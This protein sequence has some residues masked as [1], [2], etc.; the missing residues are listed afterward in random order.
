MKSIAARPW[1]R[2]SSKRANHPLRSRP[3]RSLTTVLLAVVGSVIVGTTASA[4]SVRVGIRSET[5]AV[6]APRARVSVGLRHTSDETPSRASVTLRGDLLLDWGGHG[7]IW[8]SSAKRSE[9]RFMLRPESIG[10]ARQQR[11]SPAGF[12]FTGSKVTEALGRGVDVTYRSTATGLEQEFTIARRPIGASGNVSL[13]L[14]TAGTLRAVQDRSGTRIVGDTGTIFHYGGLHVTDRSGRVLPAHLSVVGRTIR[15]VID[16]TNAAYPVTVDPYVIPPTSPAATFSGG[17]L[18]GFSVALSADGQ[19]ALVGT[20]LAY[21]GAAYLAT[22]SSGSW[23][24]TPARYIFPLH[25]D[26]RFGTS[27]ALSSNGTTALVGDPSSN[28][29]DLY[30]ESGGSWTTTPVTF[31]GASGSGFGTSVALSGDGETVLVGAPTSS[32][33]DLYDTAPPSV[34]SISPSSGPPSGGTTVTITG[35]NLEQASAVDFGSGHPATILTDTATSLTVT[36]PPESAGTVDITV[37]TPNGTSATSSA[38]EFSYAAP[39]KIQRIAPS[40]GPASGGTTVEIFGTDLAHANAVHFGK[41]AAKI[42]RG[43]AS[44]LTVISPPGTGTVTVTVTTSG[45]TSSAGHFT[46]KAS[47]GSATRRHRRSIV[48]KCTGICIFIQGGASGPPSS[49]INVTGNRVSLGGRH[50]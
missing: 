42:T 11:F 47:R 29:A 33:A 46:Y 30:T 9:Q 2:S 39:P 25:F 50:S 5:S 1:R 12:V 27:V 44:A 15:L 3:A 13:L 19:T 38:D 36:S 45:G 24:S 40:N 22:E 6:P 10:R 48:Y 43:S 37:T 20:P 16:D 32:A 31:T 35:A 23:S 41:A 21:I 28:A 14:S 49:S 34:T 17:G 4:G 8:I 26:R 18:F 7:A